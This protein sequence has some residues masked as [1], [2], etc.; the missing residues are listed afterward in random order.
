[1]VYAFFIPEDFEPT[2]SGMAIAFQGK[3]PF[4]LFGFRLLAGV[5]YIRVFDRFGQ[6]GGLNWGRHGSIL[7]A[8][9]VKRGREVAMS[10][11]EMCFSVAGP[12]PHITPGLADRGGELAK[13]ADPTPSVLPAGNPQA[14]REDHPLV[15]QITIN[16]T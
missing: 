5:S 6:W 14:D 8:P 7:P 3:R 10:I 4:G 12:P 16:R 11:M 15:P 9:R 2:S 13:T 1:M